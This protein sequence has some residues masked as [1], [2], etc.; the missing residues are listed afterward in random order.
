MYAVVRSG[1]KQYR[2]EEGTLLTIATL[3][4]D[5]GKQ[6]TFEDVLMVADGDEVR[7]KPRL[8][9]TGEIVAHGKGEKI[10]VFRYKNKTRQRK[11]T[12]HRQGTTTVRI[13]RIE[14][15]WGDEPGNRSE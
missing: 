5:P 3:S 1:G 6:I 11:K 13:T 12:G 10:T 7:E 2:V 8:T 4:G 15:G 9:V 14:P